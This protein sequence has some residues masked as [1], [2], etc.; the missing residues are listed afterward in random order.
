MEE[1]KKKIFIITLATVFAIYLLI[2]PYNKIAQIGYVLNNIQLLMNN[3]VVDEYLFHRNN[4]AYLLKMN[5]RYSA[6][7]EMD[8]AIAT[9]PST[10]SDSVLNRFYIERARIKLLNQ[11]YKSALNDFLRVPTHSINDYLAIAMLLKKN[12]NRKLA[13]TYCNK[14]IDIDIK[15]YAGYACIADIYGSLKKYDASIMI[16]DLLIDRSPNKAKYYADRAMYK[17]KAGDIKGADQDLKKAKELS[18]L[19]NDN[20]SITYDAL[21]PKKINMNIMKS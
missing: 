2:P 1:D 18:P 19:F 9:V 16:Y 5:N 11:D 17:N 13:V 4:A 14:I 6:S 10:I 12:G 3:K 15:A 7:K 21:H 8:K 20:S